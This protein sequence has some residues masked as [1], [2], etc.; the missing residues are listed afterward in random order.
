VMFVTVA[1][2]WIIPDRR[3]VRALGLDG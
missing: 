2:I 1:F 3:V